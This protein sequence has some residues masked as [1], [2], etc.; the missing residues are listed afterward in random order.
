MMENFEEEY[1]TGLPVFTALFEL[2]KPELMDKLKSICADSV[3]SADLF[4]HGRVIK[5]TANDTPD[6]IEVWFYDHLRISP[7][8]I[9]YHPEHG[10]AI[11]IINFNEH[12][13]L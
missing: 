4:E 11:T 6:F 2:K 8:G 1:K 12:F 3:V 10:E 9:N 13:K 5:Q 7:F